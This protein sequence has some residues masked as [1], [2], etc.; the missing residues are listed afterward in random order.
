MK[1]NSSQIFKFLITLSLLIAITP[2]SA[3]TGDGWPD[4]YRIGPT[5]SP[6]YIAITIDDAPMPDVRE[7]LDLLDVLNIKA[8]FFVEGEFV[9]WRPEGLVAIANAGHEIGNHS[10]DHPNMTTVD[11][12]ELKHQFIDTNKLVFDLT[13]TRIHLFRP[14][15]GNYD[16]HVVD[17]A[18]EN[19]M[20]TVLWTANAGDYLEPP[21]S[22]IYR[23]I[24]QRASNGGIILMHD[25]IQQTREALPLI[26][27]TLRNQG[28]EF[29]TVGEMLEMTHGECQW[30]DE[31]E[32]ELPEVVIIPRL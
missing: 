32:P 28:Y 17:V 15:G 27:E 23:K 3:D 8:T 29:V 5:G 10:W 24:T 4:L 19:E 2:I 16:D 9:N 11:D 31:E 30:E 7:M 21:P 26:V 14:P 1:K 6:K 12:D 13:G 22:E 18:Y 25:G 20:T